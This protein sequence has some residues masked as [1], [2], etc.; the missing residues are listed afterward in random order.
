M[1]QIDLKRYLD[2]RGSAVLANE[3]RL[4]ELGLDVVKSPVGTLHQGAGVFGLYD[5]AFERRDPNF[6]AELV[7][8]LRQKVRLSPAGV[9]QL[10][11]QSKQ[12]R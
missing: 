10:E 5:L 6:S 9:Q 4:H 12:C 11:Q 7:E 2:E 8:F 1:Q 3:H